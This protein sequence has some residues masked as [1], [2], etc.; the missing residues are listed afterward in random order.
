LTGAGADQTDKCSLYT[1]FSTALA[2]TKGEYFLD[3]D[4]QLLCVQGSLGKLIEMMK[5]E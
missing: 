4:T 1:C 5:D 2:E 3:L